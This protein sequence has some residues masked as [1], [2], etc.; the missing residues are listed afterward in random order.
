MSLSSLS[1]RTHGSLWRRRVSRMVAGLLITAGLAQPAHAASIVE[2][3]AFATQDQSLWGSGAANIINKT[4]FVGIDWNKSLTIGGF[5]LGTGAQV[6]G[7]SK[8]KV[9]F[10]YELK[11]DPGS[12][13]ANLGFQYAIAFPSPNDPQF[14][15]AGTLPVLFLSRMNDTSTFETNFPEFQ[16]AV[17]FVFE[18]QGTIGG[19]VQIAG[20]SASGSFTLPN[21]AVDAELIAVNRNGDGKFALLRDLPV[22]GIEEDLSVDFSAFDHEKDDDNDNGGN[23]GGNNGGSDDSKKKQKLDS[24][25]LSVELSIPDVSVTGEL[26]AYNKVTGKGEDE[27]LRVGIDLDGLITRALSLPPLEAEVSAG[28]FT[29]GY[30]IL[31]VEAG[32][33]FQI[34]QDF[35]L[36]GDLVLDL[37]STEGGTTTVDMP[38]LKL[39]FNSFDT[40]TSGYFTHVLYNNALESNGSDETIPGALGVNKIFDEDYDLFDTGISGLD[41]E[42]VDLKQIIIND[43][44]QPVLK[45]LHDPRQAPRLELTIPELFPISG[46]LTAQEMFD[47]LRTQ[48]LIVDAELAGYRDQTIALGDTGNIADTGTLVLGN[49]ISVKR[50]GGTITDVDSSYD[51]LYLDRGPTQSAP[52]DFKYDLF[53]TVISGYEVVYEPVTINLPGNQVIA[54]L[55]H[56]QTADVPVGTQLETRLRLENP[57]LVNTTGIRI[58]PY[59]SFEILAAA[60][61][62][63]GIGALDLG[64]LIEKTFSVAGVNTP[65]L[66]HQAFELQ[67]FGAMEQAGP[68]FRVG[69]DNPTAAIPG[70]L[71][72]VPPPIRPAQFP[73]QLVRS[74][75]VI[76]SD[77]DP[78]PG[79]VIQGPGTAVIVTDIL[80][81]SNLVAKL[82]SGSPVSI[83]SEFDISELAPGGDWDFLLD[84]RFLSTSNT[85]VLDIFV[86]D[87]AGINTLQIGSLVASDYLPDAWLNFAFRVDDTRFSSGPVNITIRWNDIVSGSEIMIDNAAIVPFVPEP[88]SGTLMLLAGTALLRRRRTA[89]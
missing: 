79:W 2:N 32:P 34:T 82:T 20:A 70:F 4:G 65:P 71:T 36:T 19:E 29:F 9:G 42:W 38:F 60:I 44:Q 86:A 25:L 10:E 69:V 7:T 72:E 88:A 56:G 51:D 77:G 21:I 59:M 47:Q 1:G 17:D 53:D 46:G 68:T 43:N 87:L 63:D 54:T 45:G 41:V 27:F 76:G 40:N 85:G 28:P 14:Q 58:D 5:V 89:R 83:T 16:A 37:I 3:V 24:E 80:N 31:D 84:V 49:G 75:D 52:I 67:G 50:S 26:T 74:F 61:G 18:H 15:N 81:P 23:N 35:A 30:N 62:A 57:T 66:F 6:T 39:N 55:R 22:F 73:P 13:D 78:V 33:L 8:G 64:P 12:V 48:G 11:I